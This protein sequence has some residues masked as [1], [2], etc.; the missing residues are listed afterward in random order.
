MPNLGSNSSALRQLL[1][2]DAK[3][4]WIEEHSK[5]FHDLQFLVTNSPLLKY[6][7]PNLPV[8][9]IP[10]GGTVNNM[11]VCML[12]TLMIAKSL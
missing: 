12:V 7:D 11:Y 9:I 2:K 5:Q 3:W 8:S 10:F 4:E 6:L 1:V